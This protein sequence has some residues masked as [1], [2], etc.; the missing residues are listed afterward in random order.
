MVCVKDEVIKMFFS[1]SNN[2]SIGFY[3]SVHL[4]REFHS[5]HSWYYVLGDFK[6]EILVDRGIWSTY[7]SWL[8]SQLTCIKE[9]FTIASRLASPFCPGWAHELVNFWEEV[10]ILCTC[11]WTCVSAVHLVNKACEGQGGLVNAVFLCSSKA[12][13]GSTDTNGTFWPLSYQLWTELEQI[14]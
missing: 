1:S 6:W 3:S 9:R 10:K 13:N 2:N 14:F 8:A 4:W 11:R 12:G 5:C 7:S